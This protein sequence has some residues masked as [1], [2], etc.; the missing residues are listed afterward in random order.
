MAL[1]PRLSQELA[2]LEDGLLRIEIIED[3][4]FVNVVFKDF[5][6]GAPFNLSASD[7]LIRVPR[8]YP[9]TGPDM[10]WASPNLLLADGRV[11]RGGESMETHAGRSWRRFSWHQA[12]WRPTS[13]NLHSHLEF[14]RKRLRQNE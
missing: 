12:S 8:A 11:P 4:D 3:S 2:A 13:D 1:P 6:I 9:D 10:F 14:V 5:L 7:L